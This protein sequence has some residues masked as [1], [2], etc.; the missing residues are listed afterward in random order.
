MLR[1]GQKKVAGGTP[2]TAVRRGWCPTNRKM[3]NEIYIL[4]S[5]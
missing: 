3:E 2:A 4:D 5:S 1:S